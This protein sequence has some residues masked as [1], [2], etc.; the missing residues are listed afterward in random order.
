MSKRSE[1]E[2]RRRSRIVRLISFLVVN[3][4]FT[5]VLVVVAFFYG[6][7]SVSR[8]LPDLRGW[9]LDAPPSEFRARDESRRFTFA[10]LLAREDRAFA[11]LAAFIRED[12]TDEQPSGLSRYRPDSVSNPDAILPRN[13][14]RTFVFE[15]DAPI[16]GALLL[17]GLSDSPYSLRAIGERLHKEGYTVIGLRIPGHGTCPAAL[18]EA[19]WQDW[20]AAV[21]IA[22]RGLRDKVPSSSPLVLVGFSNG[23]ALAVDY[24][25][26]A[27]DDPALPQPAAITLFAPMIGITAL[28][29]IT[30]LYP[31]AARISGQEKIAWSRIQPE[32]E[33]FRYSSWPTNGSLQAW[34]MTQRV[35]RGLARLQREARMDR[36]PPVY[37]VQSV[38]DATVQVPRLIERLF[39]RLPPGKSELLLFDVNRKAWL[40]E[41]I[42]FDFEQGV[43]P[44]LSRP[45]LPFTLSFVT[46]VD[47]NSLE[48]EL[49][50]RRAGELTREPLGLAWPDEI[51]SMSHA[52]PPIPA[53][54]P[55]L[56][57]AAATEGVG[58]PL[59]SLSLRGESGVLAIAD[60]SLVRL[61]H[62]PFYEFTEDRVI[63]WLRRTLQPAAPAPPNPADPPPPAN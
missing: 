2:A 32:I 3:S 17:H 24:A 1:S 31:V 25:I 61:R 6:W 42:S 40:E 18:A 48:V 46:N 54:D 52:S 21:R 37:T 19:R 23:G 28:A 58:L 22:M 50:T 27:M 13:W 15:H 63:E 35:E 16:G 53:D 14:N 44:R 33:P 56:G 51:F 39:D 36:F 30:A 5:A 10:D 47:E 38:V 20:A 7:S 55:I 57:T 29:E 34:R 26:S 4:I 45:D 41:L 12:W 49:R 11:E 62:N 60:A 9:H 59:G 43:R 8:N